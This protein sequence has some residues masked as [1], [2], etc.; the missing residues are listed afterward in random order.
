MKIKECIRCKKVLSINNFYK[1]NS[2]L[3]GYKEVCKFCKKKEVKEKSRAFPECNTLRTVQSRCNN[4][5]NKCY[6]NYGLR[7]IKC[8]I[9]KEE[10]KKLMIRDNFG[11]LYNPTI[12]RIDNDGNYTFDNC[13]FI[14]M[15]KNISKAHSKIV[16]QYDLQGNFIKEW[17]SVRIASKETGI[18]YSTIRSV[19]QGKQKTAG[20]FIWKYK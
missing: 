8:L 12:D 1:D 9:T 15:V 2:R 3:D 7:G 13:Q 6:K 19:A 5:N 16:L 18:N 10:I 14:E 20:G 4:P 11:S 17:P